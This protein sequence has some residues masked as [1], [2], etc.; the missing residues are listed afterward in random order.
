MNSLYADNYEAHEWI[1][2]GVF[3]QAD[4]RE[5]GM[6]RCCHTPDDII[7]CNSDSDEVEQISDEDDYFFFDDE[8]IAAGLPGNLECELLRLGSTWG[9]HEEG[10]LVLIVQTDRNEFEVFV[11][12]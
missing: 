5:S 6:M 10:R 4:V 7:A 11:E 1:R 12:K 9:S 8:Q 2:K 3:D